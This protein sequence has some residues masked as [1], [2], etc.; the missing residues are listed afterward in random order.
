MFSYALFATAGLLMSTSTAAAP[1]PAADAALDTPSSFNPQNYRSADHMP[2]LAWFRGNTSFPIA[3]LATAALDGKKAIKN[4][5]LNSET[6]KKSTI[7][8]D[9]NDLD[10]V[11]S[12]HVSCCVGH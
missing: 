4:Y 7:Y 12:F 9:W 1:R 3:K 2:P 8:G 10:G 11:C 5:Q 6:S